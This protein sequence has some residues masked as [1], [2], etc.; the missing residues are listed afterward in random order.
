MRFDRSAVTAA[1]MLLV[2]LGAAALQASA[3]AKNPDRVAYSGETQVHT[4][5][6]LDAWPF[7]NRITHPRDAYK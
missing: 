7:G 2:V 3:Q 1:L 4:S 5:W 6:S